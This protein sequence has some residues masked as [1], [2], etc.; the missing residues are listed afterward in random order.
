[1][2]AKTLNPQI[3]LEFICYLF[4]GGLMYYLVRSGEYLN[5]VTPRMKPYLYFTGVVM[6]IW[7]CTGLFRL[8]RPQHRIRSA[9]CFVLMIPILF[10][11]LPHNPLSTVDL[12]ANYAGRNTFANSG[13]NSNGLE[14]SLIEEQTSNTNDAGSGEDLSDSMDTSVSD[15]GNGMAEEEYLN[16]LPGLDEQNRTITV[17]NEDFGMWLSE[18]Y[19][20]MSKYEGYK[21]IMTGFV[22]KNE[23]FFKENEFIPARLSMSCC[24]ADLAPTGLLCQYDKVSELKADSWVTVEGTLHIAK[25]N[26]DNVE[27]EDPQI[28]VTKVTPAKEVEG[29]VY[30]Y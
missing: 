22:F 23:D 25:Y 3:F 30:P 18:I 12:S 2:Q 10:L 7:A 21:I 28:S 24:V 20:N 27:Y 15:E 4:F 11:L 1:M 6:V 19:V 13:S 8:F 17:A 29:Y 26:Y 16:D 14:P 9:H 5:Y